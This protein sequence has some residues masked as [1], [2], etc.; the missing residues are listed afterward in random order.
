MP[1]RAPANIRATSLSTRGTWA[2]EELRAFQF[3]QERLSVGVKIGSSTCPFWHKM[4]PQSSQT[5]P[6][7]K[8]M[9]VA[10]ASLYES[11]DQA[12]NNGSAPL[13]K[14][15]LSLRQCNLAIRELISSIKKTTPKEVLLTTCVLLIWFE[16]LRSRPGASYKYLRLGLAMLQ[17]NIDDALGIMTDASLAAL[18]GSRPMN[19]ILSSMYAKITATAQYAGWGLN[20]WYHEG[21][22]KQLDL[23]YLDSLLP[24]SFGSIF[25][26]WSLS[27]VL[28]MTCQK[29]LQNLSNRAYIPPTHPLAI[30]LNEKVRIFIEGHI[31]MDGIHCPFPDPQPRILST[32]FNVLHIAINCQITTNDESSFDDYTPQFR[33]IVRTL[34]DAI[35]QCS[36][37]KF[38]DYLS[39]V[40]FGVWSTD[41]LYFVASNC[42]DPTVRREAIDVLLSHR[43]REACLDGWTAG[44]LAE[45]KMEIEERGLDQVKSCLDIPPSRRIRIHDATF[46]PATSEVVF[47]YMFAPYDDAS[48]HLY[49]ER[50]SWPVRVHNLAVDEAP[51]INQLL[52]AHKLFLK[53]PAGDAVGGTLQPMIY[54]D[55]PVEVAAE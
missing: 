4:V 48:C 38:N 45:R 19:I 18:L 8:H 47:R 51:M 12:P 35:M 20:Q 2:L 14:Q 17:Q 6:A 49:A 13:S 25:Q 55:Q 23:G 44:K 37:V 15:S 40:P 9:A 5:F 39:F 53:A 52:Q 28:R 29:I 11:I 43:R 27:E 1:R 24:K 36:A 41:R 33:E 26:L 32:L 22:D 10:V 31:S 34:R 46:D 7:V 42:R 3:Y 30:A 16:L 50:I 21:A 54:R